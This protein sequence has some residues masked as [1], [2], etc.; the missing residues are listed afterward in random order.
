MYHGRRRLETRVAPPKFPRH[1]A[2]L[3]PY[4]P[5]AAQAQKVHW[6]STRVKCQG[7]RHGTTA[8]LNQ[9]NITLI[10]FTI[11]PFGSFGYFATRLLYGTPTIHAPPG[12]NLLIS[13]RKQHTKPLLLPLLPHELFSPGPILSM[14]LLLPLG[15]H[16]TRTPE[17][18]ATQ[19]LGA[20]AHFLLRATASA[21]LAPAERLRATPKSH[22][23]LGVNMA[24]FF[25]CRVLRTEHHPHIFAN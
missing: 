12:M 1:D 15:T 16:S 2:P 10:P 24:F 21:I 11:D 23:P 5:Y 17:Q 22:P 9:V 25:P 6:G 18:W 19:I 14:M 7:Q 13:H 4:N 20:S 8:N 3:N